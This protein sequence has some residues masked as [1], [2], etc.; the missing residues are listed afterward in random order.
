MFNSYAINPMQMNQMV[1]G[2]NPY[3]EVDPERARQMA[4][5]LANAGIT[6]GQIAAGFLTGPVGASL[7]YGG[8]E[9]AKQM[10]AG[11][12]P[13]Q[14]FQQGTQAGILDFGTNAALLKIPFA[15][16]L[17]GTIRKTPKKGILKAIGKVDDVIEPTYFHHTN[18]DIKE[19]NPYSQFTND[20]NL[21]SGRGTKTYE[22]NLDIKNPYTKKE[23]G[24]TVDFDDLIKRGYDAV[25][26]KAGK[27]FIPL[28][29]NQIKIK[30]IIDKGLKK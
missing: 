24:E 1:P 15:P 6:G 11:Q 2:A 29:Q 9:I 5:Q 14:S 3:G 13:M 26:N 7:A 12:N 23:A 18:A 22:V 10:I 25:V 4:I 27:I 30:N 19:F 21:F 28:K 17:A 20:P 8:G 16:L